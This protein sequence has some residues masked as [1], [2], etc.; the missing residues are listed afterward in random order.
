MG[1]IYSR[2]V[3]V[4]NFM[5]FLVAALALAKAAA[6]DASGRWVIAAAVV[7]GIL[8]IG[9]GWVAFGYSPGDAAASRQA[10]MSD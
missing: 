2:P 10:R 3:S 5:H 1:G 4:G 7:Y 8:A 9:F 6:G